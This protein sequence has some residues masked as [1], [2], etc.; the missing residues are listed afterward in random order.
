M[1]WRLFSS[2]LAPLSWR[3]QAERGGDPLTHAEG[4]REEE[5]A[6]AD[7]S[8]Q[9]REEGVPRPHGHQLQR[10]LS[11]RSQDGQGGPSGQGMAT[12]QHT[13]VPTT[14]CKSFFYFIFSHL[15]DLS[16]ASLL[17]TSLQ[18]FL[19][20]QSMGLD[21]CLINCNILQWISFYFRTQECRWI[22][23]VMFDTWHH[24][25]EEVLYRI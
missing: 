6:A 11:L 5:E 24:I 3:R 18:L 7:D 12:L 15:I 22:A 2:L 20:T 4:S 17:L 25:Q 9:R 23:T 19:I 8:D 13:T 14:S 16:T 21:C 10:H 1:D